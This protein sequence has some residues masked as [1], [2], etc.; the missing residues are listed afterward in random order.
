MGL[1]AVVCLDAPVC[2]PK[3]HNH[4]TFFKERG[5]EGETDRQTKREKGE[6]KG[7]GKALIGFFSYTG[8]WTARLQ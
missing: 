4:I 6:G 3:I 8:A 2:L 7:T 5:R 1:K